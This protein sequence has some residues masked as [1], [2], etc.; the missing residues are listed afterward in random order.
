MTKAG[1]SSNG[2]RF[3]V[4]LG[5]VFLSGYHVFGPSA[6]QHGRLNYNDVT[7]IDAT[8][9]SNASLSGGVMGLGAGRGS[10]TLGVVPRSVQL[11]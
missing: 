9:L 11:P 8:V 2:A 6:I 10:A 7:E 5:V 4:A 1:R 3:A